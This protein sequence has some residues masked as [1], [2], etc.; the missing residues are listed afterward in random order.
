[1][2][3]AR[4]GA[5]ARATMS[6]HNHSSMPWSLRLVLLLVL[7]GAGVFAWGK[8]PF[9]G[10]AEKVCRVAELSACPWSES[11]LVGND[12]K[13][14]WL[15][16]SMWRFGRLAQLPRGGGPGGGD[17]LRAL[18]REAGLFACPE[19]DVVDREFEKR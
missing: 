18:A 4:R 6:P 19:A 13:I 11:S 8:R 15:E 3:Q 2:R 17:F 14:A 1:M 12:C 16:H 10:D 7:A 5:D 9:V